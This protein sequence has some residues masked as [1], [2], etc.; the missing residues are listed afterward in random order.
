VSIVMIGPGHPARHFRARQDR[1]STSP[2]HRS[3]HPV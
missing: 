1:R 2:D 3:C